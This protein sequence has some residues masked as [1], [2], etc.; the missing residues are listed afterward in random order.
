[1]TAICAQCH[2]RGGRSKSTGLPYPSTFIAGDNLFKDFN[3]DFVRADGSALNPGDRHILRNVRDVAVGGASAPICTTCHRIHAQSSDRHR[4][5]PRTATCADCHQFDG[6][7]VRTPQYV[8]DSAL[9]EYEG[10]KS[11]R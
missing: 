6:T 5:L 7:S 8:V 1:M 4:F 9:C 2:L 3:V 10:V 11:G